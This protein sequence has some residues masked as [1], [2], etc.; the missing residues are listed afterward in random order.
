MILLSHLFS[1]GS[2]TTEH[3]CGGQRTTFMESGVRIL[4]PTMWVLGIEFRWSSLAKSAL[5]TEPSHQPGNFK[6][7]Q[8]LAVFIWVYYLLS[9]YYRIS[10]TCMGDVITQPRHEESYV[11]MSNF[12]LLQTQASLIGWNLL[13]KNLKDGEMAQRVS[14]LAT[15]CGTWVL[16]LSWF[17]RL[18]TELYMCV[19][20][21]MPCG[22][23]G[24]YLN[25]NTQEA[26]AGRSQGQP[27]VFSE[28]Q[29]D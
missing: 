13:K 12:W 27:G 11:I 23:S 16:L 6:Y 24:I 14:A 17:Q 29:A 5:P 21:C 28:F 15:K 20:A 4:P 19:T 1:R 18:S 9:Y 3:T 26:E 25:P 22:Q 7:W 10:A 2:Q 8:I